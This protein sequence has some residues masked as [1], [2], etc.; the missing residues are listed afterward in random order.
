MQILEN[1][2]KIAH[3]NN[4]FWGAYIFWIKLDIRFVFFLKNRVFNVFVSI[5]LY[6]ACLYDSY[7]RS[8][9]DV[10]IKSYEVCNI[11]SIHY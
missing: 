7:E 1:V 10:W 5:S 3:A 11:L 9:V 8:N 4:D 2:S 6:L